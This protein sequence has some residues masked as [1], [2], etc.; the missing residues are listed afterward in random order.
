M[1]ENMYC[2]KIFYVYSRYSIGGTHAVKA[3]ASSVAPSNDGGG[4]GE[5]KLL[6]RGC[7]GDGERRGRDGRVTW[8]PGVIVALVTGCARPWESDG[9]REAAAAAA[10]IETCIGF[11]DK[12]WS[13]APDDSENTGR[14]WVKQLNC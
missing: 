3:T 9:R 6:R 10:A 12:H 2:A 5:L 11:N 13:L 1:R 4:N 14:L 8:A 7:V